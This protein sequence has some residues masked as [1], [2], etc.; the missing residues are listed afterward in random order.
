MRSGKAY[1]LDY[2]GELQLFEVKDSR[3]RAVCIIEFATAEEIERSKTLGIKTETFSPEYI[4]TLRFEHRR[5]VRR[6]F[7]DGRRRPARRKV[8]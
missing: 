4:Q 2:E 6:R 7:G 1:V 5:R 8:G 3:L